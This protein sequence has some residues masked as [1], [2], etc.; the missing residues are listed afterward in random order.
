MKKKSIEINYKGLKLTAV[1]TLYIEDL[2]TNYKSSFGLE[3]LLSESEQDVIDI[4]EEKIIDEIEYICYE[5]LA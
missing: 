5:K 2:A 4:F 3:K 1:G